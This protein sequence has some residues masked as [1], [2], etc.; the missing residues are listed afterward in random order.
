MP[1]FMHEE[2]LCICQQEHILLYMSAAKP[3]NGKVWGTFTLM[4]FVLDQVF[5]GGLLF[6]E[7]SDL[8][9]RW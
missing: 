6:F 1:I 9:A 7:S 2:I 8:Q 3:V 5:W 4:D